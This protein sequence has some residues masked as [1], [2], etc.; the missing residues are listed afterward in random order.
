MEFNSQDV[1][2]SSSVLKYGNES[3]LITNEV[4]ELIKDKVSLITEHYQKD[5]NLF[6]KNCV[7]VF[8]YFYKERKKWEL[9]YLIRRVTEEYINITYA[10]VPEFKYLVD[11]YGP[12]LRA[13]RCYKEENE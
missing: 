5:D 12:L 1:I 7:E 10:V 11:N 13:A 6:R 8:E 2:D 4:Q 9:I 3:P